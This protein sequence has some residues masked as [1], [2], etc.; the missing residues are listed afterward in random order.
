M[1]SSR[2]EP[3]IINIFWIRTKLRNLPKDFSN[4]FQNPD[5]FTN[6]FNLTISTCDSGYSNLLQTI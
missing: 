1:V 2:R 3:A 6:E 4:F 5:G